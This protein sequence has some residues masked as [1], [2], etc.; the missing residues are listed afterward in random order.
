MRSMRRFT[1]MHRGIQAA[2]AA[3]LVVAGAAALAP[4]AA[5]AATDY[6]AL[7]EQL[8][9]ARPKLQTAL[10][11]FQRAADVAAFPADKPG[12]A[13][14]RYLDTAWKA[15]E[16]PTAFPEV[17][18]AL[19]KFHGTLDASN[20][21]ARQALGVMLGDY[22]Q[23]RYGADVLR[24]LR[25][26][27]ACKSY[28]T[29]VDKNSDN[30]EVRK[31]FDVIAGLA[32]RLG[33]QAKNHEYETLEVTLAG[34][35]GPAVAVYTHADVPKPVEHKWDSK[36]FELN[37][38]NE[39][40]VGLGVYDGKGPIIVNLFALRVLR[41]AGLKL[42]RPAVVLVSANGEEADAS[43]ATSIAVVTPK[44]AV[45]LA[46]DG[47]FPYATGEMGHLVARVASTRGMKSRAGIQP[48]EFYVYKAQ[49]DFGTSTVP[50]EARVW[51]RYEPP[52][53]TDNPSSVMV[54]G[55]WRPTIEAF[56]KQHP[57]SVYETYIQ[58]DTLHFF[59]YGNP[60]HVMHADRAENSILNA[61][62]AVLTLP[63]LFKNS[64][65]DVMLWI[66][67]GF[68]RDVTGKTIGLDFSDP[69]MGHCWVNPV[70]FDR[71]GE[72]FTSLL[73]IRW[74]V[75]HTSADVK[76]RVQASID[77]FNKQ[78]GLNLKL[79]WEPGGH[80][81]ARI[82]PPRDVTSVLEESAALASGEVT[83][84]VAATASA[85]RLLPETIPF[86]PQWPRSEPRG[87]TRNESISQR[88]LQDL[89]VAYVAVLARLTTAAALPT[90]P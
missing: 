68:A 15:I 48:G 51:V 34:A 40:W 4:R 69:D 38:W 52:A 28:N 24:E 3:A 39:R 72:E 9:V 23:V 6:L 7:R 10:Q 87:H 27:V 82:T 73:D 66:D 33:L 84:P 2:A 77:A 63:G 85:A 8:E 18:A 35:A 19:G 53:N 75:G 31:A 81:P 22:L 57:A 89:C 71:L 60:Q 26:L 70:G 37:K 17:Y 36:P 5:C 46:A 42:A 62:G 86:G 21:V 47:E 67:K 30:P 29:V 43:A 49:C 79:D 45:V 74:P 11:T 76:Q 58:D 56:Q 78:N 25:P 12:V 41:D 50:M 13:F 1:C 32:T 20:P 65:S 88:E 80:E 54:N 59:A 61:S 14:Q 44:P 64:A 83:S 90:T 16:A 55:K